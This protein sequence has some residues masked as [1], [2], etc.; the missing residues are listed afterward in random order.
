VS[1]DVRPRGHEITT[2]RVFHKDFV[3]LE[4]QGMQAS[5][6][7]PR[8][9]G[10]HLGSGGCA[11]QCRK[12]SGKGLRGA[13]PSRLPDLGVVPRMSATVSNTGCEIG[14]LPTRLANAVMMSGHSSR[15]WAMRSSLV[16]ITMNS[17]RLAS[18]PINSVQLCQ[19]G[20]TSGRVLSDRR[21]PLGMSCNSAG[22]TRS[23]ACPSRT[24]V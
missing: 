11:P 23:R 15:F 19:K 1:S 16:L 13:C 12:V 3:G 17:I 2:F 22:C 6:I 18:A 7:R 4:R 24:P 20:R 21:A 9:S 8:A 5:R 10:L 14:S